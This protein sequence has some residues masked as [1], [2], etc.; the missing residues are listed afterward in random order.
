[1]KNLAFALIVAAAG[2]L[3]PLAA[4]GQSVVFDNGNVDGRFASAS[5]PGGGAFEI[6]SADDFVLGQHTSI[7]GASF[8]GL[9]PTGASLASIGSVQVEIYRVFP[10]DSNTG[11]TSGAPTF[12]TSQVPTR[13]NS[14]SD[15]AFLTRGSAAGTLTFATAVLSAS[16]AVTN[17]LQPGGIHGLPN[18]TNGGTGP[19]AGQEV[20]FDVTFTTPFDLAADHYFFVP[21]VALATPGSFLWLSST[22]PIVA[23]GTPFSPD[24]QAWARDDALDPDWLRIGTDIVGGAPAPTYNLAFSL[25]GDAVAAAVPEP[26]TWALFA[27]GVALLAVRG[28]R[29]SAAANRLR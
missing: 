25:K 26:E 16:L 5:R 4:L 23:P 27:A 11:R 29:R 15:V 18:I 10:N 2:G 24:L 7:T 8:Y 12:S 3:G 9:L 17:S 6:E 1:M 22:R 21:Q 28:R 19:V 14:P 13:V 20:R